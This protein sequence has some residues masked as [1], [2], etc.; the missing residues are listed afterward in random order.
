M[1]KFTVPEA[2]IH[3]FY[4]HDPQGLCKMGAPFDEY[5]PEIETI[6]PRIGEAKSSDD[7]AKI[8]YQEFVAW[9]GEFGSGTV[10]DYRPLAMD[11]WNMR[12]LL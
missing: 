11:L 8:I 6:L 10:E 7:L 1:S 9:F 4:N 5:V 3:L 12:G 2:L